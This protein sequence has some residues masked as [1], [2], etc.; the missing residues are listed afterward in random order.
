[1][2]K[3]LVYSA[4]RSTFGVFGVS[5][6]FDVVFFFEIESQVCIIRFEEN[7]LTMIW[8]SLTLLGEYQ[9]FQVR[10]DVLKHGK[11]LASLDVDRFNFEI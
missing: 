1:V 7:A 4:V 5:L 10:V 9:G 11:S 6:D 2:I 8:S 3:S